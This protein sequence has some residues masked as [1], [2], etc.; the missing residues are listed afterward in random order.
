MNNSPHLDRPLI[1]FAIALPRMLAKIEANLATA[2]PAET[3]ESNSATGGGRS[4][5]FAAT[6][7]ELGRTGTPPEMDTLARIDI[8]AP[9]SFRPDRRTLDGPHGASGR[10][11]TD[12]SFHL[13]GVPI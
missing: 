8:D 13:P 10:L 12:A 6:F 5:A 9:G 4:V 2:G 7:L 11:R 3:P 1:P